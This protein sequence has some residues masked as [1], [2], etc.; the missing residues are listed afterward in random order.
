MSAFGTGSPKSQYQM[1]LNKDGRG[2]RGGAGFGAVSL[3]SGAGVA[4]RISV[5]AGASGFGGGLACSY[6]AAGSSRGWTS[7]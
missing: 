2:A 6:F 3:V 1:R 5:T 4:G 7:L